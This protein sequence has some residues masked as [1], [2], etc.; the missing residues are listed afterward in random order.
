MSMILIKLL[1]LSYLNLSKDPV[2]GLCYPYLVP[3][4]TYFLKNI[5]EKRE[6]KFHPVNYEA[7]NSASGMNIGTI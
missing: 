6:T 7:S 2:R 5:T 1:T 3:F 4:G